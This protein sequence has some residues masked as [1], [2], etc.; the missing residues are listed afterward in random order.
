M[1][2]HDGGVPVRSYEV[3]SDPPGLT[4]A[5]GGSETTALVPQLGNGTAYR[6]RVVAIGDGGR[7]TPSEWSAAVTPA[8]PPRMELARLSRT[9]AQTPAAPGGEPGIMSGPEL[10]LGFELEDVSTGDEPG[11]AAVTCT[12]DDEP[13]FACSS[14]VRL[15]NLP[16]GKH[17]LVVVAETAGGRAR[18]EMSFE[19][20]AMPPVARSPRVAALA[21]ER[22]HRLVWPPAPDEGSG[23]AGYDLRVRQAGLDGP[24]RTLRPP[25]LSGTTRRA[26]LDLP[27]GTSTCISLQARDHTANVSA[28]SSERCVTRPVDDADLRAGPGWRRHSDPQRYGGG[29]LR[30][31]RRGAEIRA[32]V[33]TTRKVT[34]LVGRCARCGRLRVAADGRPVRTVDLG[35]PG[36]GAVTVSLP[37]AAARQLTLTVLSDG[38]PVAAK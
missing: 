18:E 3:E 38:R 28:W 23:V 2:E 20:D 37:R 31:S 32:S 15:Q 27:P 34:L 17:T 5:S 36:P 14:P 10:V 13:P 35:Q 16:H 6:F 11:S 25:Q 4:V 33:G 12:L 9:V 1:P 7:S 26:E 8:G 22:E 19:V 21:L 24:F 30:A 29:V